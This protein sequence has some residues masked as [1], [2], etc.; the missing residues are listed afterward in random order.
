MNSPIE[1]RIERLERLHA[2][3]LDRGT[4]LIRSNPDIAYRHFDIC[5]LL[6]QAMARIEESRA[7]PPAEVA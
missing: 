6:I 1:A 3:Y 2:A 5:R 4:A 7:E